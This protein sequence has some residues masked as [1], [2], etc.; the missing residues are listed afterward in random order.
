MTAREKPEKKKAAK[1][2]AGTS[3]E[4]LRPDSNRLERRLRAAKPDKSS[5]QSQSVSVKELTAAARSAKAKYAL[6]AVEVV[7]YHHIG[8]TKSY[9]QAERLARA[10]EKEIILQLRQADLVAYTGEGK[11]FIYMHETGKTESTMVLERLSRLISRRNQRRSIAPQISI[12]FK[13]IDAQLTKDAA[14]LQ[15][16]EE[17]DRFANW[18]QRYQFKAPAA[19]DANWHELKAKDTWNHSRNVLIRRFDFSAKTQEGRQRVVKTLSLIQTNGLSLFSQLHD[20]YSGECFLC[21]V[22]EPVSDY[23]DLDS[24]EP[25]IKCRHDI[26]I[27]ICDLYVQLDGFDLPPPAFPSGDILIAKNESGCILDSLDK[28]L[29]TAFEMNCDWAD[30]VESIESILPVIEKF[31]KALPKDDCFSTA[32]EQLEKTSSRRAL[33]GTVQRI[34]ATLKRHEERIRRNQIASESKASD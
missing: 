27:A 32:K 12:A 29:V 20:F 19:F 9:D 17:K 16:S 11:F 30:H 3:S 6:A 2:K 33:V 5:P 7:E 31:A 18:L 10:I 4:Q 1:S 22:L 21:L 15:T 28:H 25:S 8:R 14:T 34:R 13:L 23:R 26:L 24:A